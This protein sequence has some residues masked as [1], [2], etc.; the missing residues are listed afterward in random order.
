VG[1]AVGW[2]RREAIRRN[3]DWLSSA[4]CVCGGLLRETALQPLGGAKMAYP[5]NQQRADR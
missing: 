4:L 1:R 2:I 3:C 5:D